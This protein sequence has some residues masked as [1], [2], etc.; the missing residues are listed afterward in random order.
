[1]SHQNL[2]VSEVG[3][4]LD[5]DRP[6]IGATPDGLI[7]CTCCGK[8]TL[9]IKCPYCFKSNLPE[10]DQENFCMSL[11]DGRW[12]LKRSHAYYYQVQS[13]LAASKLSYCDFVV[14]TENGF[15]SERITFDSKFF[16][17]VMKEVHHFF[18]YGMLP[19]II[20]KWYTRKPVVDCSGVVNASFTAPSTEEDT[21]DYSK[22]WCYCSQP[23]FG[24]MIE[25]DNAQC[26]IQW[27]HCDCLRIR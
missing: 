16:E 8:G 17:D 2:V 19:E 13:Q 21:E 18:V 11:D 6:F 15:A 7:T 5:G 26:S 10:E 4:I 12:S 22:V 9:E 1:M 25:C 24:T 27:F 23:S 3:L 20:G 14:W